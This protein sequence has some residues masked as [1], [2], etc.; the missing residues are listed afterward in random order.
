MQKGTWP[1]EDCRELLELVVV[2][3]GDVVKRFPENNVVN[4]DVCIR[5]P[6]AV[7]RA[8]FMASCLYLIKI[9]LY[10]KQFDVALKNIQDVNIL[11]ECIA[12]LHVPDFLKSS[13]VMVKIFGSILWSTKAVILLEAANLM[14]GIPPLDSF[15]GTRSWLIFHMLGAEGG[16]LGQT[17]AEWDNINE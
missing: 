16:W 14:I 13:L 15:V 10:Q 6:G 5:K 3:L 1:R 11:A 17:V 7:H 2:F 9:S 4:V 12:L 8:R